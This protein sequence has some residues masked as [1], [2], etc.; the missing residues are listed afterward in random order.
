MENTSPKPSHNPILYCCETLFS[1]AIPLKN[2]QKAA[3]LSDEFREQIL[4]EFTAMEKKAFDLQIGMVELKDARYAMAAFIDELVL[5][6][7][8]P[9]KLEWMSKPLQLD[10]FGEHTAG[11]GFFTH[12]SNL[13]Q[14]GEENLHL[15]ELYYYCLQ[16][17]FEGIYKVKGIEK[18]MAL[19]VDLRSQID[20][21]RGTTSHQ[22]ADEGLPTHA[23]INQM[24]RQVPYWVI[25][26]ITVATV[27]F[28]YIGYSV[29]SNNLAEASVSTITKQQERILK[30]AGRSEHPANH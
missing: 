15:L 5:G 21:Y 26:V 10:F 16:L 18:L 3:V 24:R 2:D 17:G 7:N 29:V 19:Q 30:H 25:A 4:A 13:R 1:L 9:G 8:W 14:G 12:L 20:G 28:T 27:F 23:L 6:S 22:I 11:E